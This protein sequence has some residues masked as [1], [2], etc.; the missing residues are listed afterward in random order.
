MFCVCDCGQRLRQRG[1]LVSQRIVLV[2]QIVDFALQLVVLALQVLQRG[3][4]VVQLVQPLE[5]L[6]AAFFLLLQRCPRLSCSALRT[7]PMPPSVI[8]LPL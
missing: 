4:D 6:R 2:A 3:Q 1:H 5:N 8:T 7:S